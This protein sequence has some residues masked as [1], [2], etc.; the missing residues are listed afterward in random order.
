LTEV[1]SYDIGYCSDDGFLCYYT[2]N[3]K[4]ISSFTLKVEA[5]S[6][7]ETS[8]KIYYSYRYNIPE[9]NPFESYTA[10]GF[11]VFLSFSV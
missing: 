2:L 7:S 1:S 4:N 3:V 5:A 10:K 8:E 9:D 11:V 6:S